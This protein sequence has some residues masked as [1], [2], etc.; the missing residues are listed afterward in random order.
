MTGWSITTGG[1]TRI[2]GWAPPLKKGEL[3]VVKAP[4]EVE[5]TEPVE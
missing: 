4:W 2:T 1:G 3:T 5:V